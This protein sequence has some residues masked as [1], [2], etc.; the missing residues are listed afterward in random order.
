MYKIHNVLNQ[1]QLDY[2]NN[3]IKNFDYKIHSSHSAQ[4]SIT[5]FNSELLHTDKIKT[6]FFR[7]ILLKILSKSN[8]VL[9][10][11]I[12]C[13]RCYI[14]FYPCQS[15]G[16]FHVDSEGGNLTILYFP[17]E[18]DKND[19]GETIFLEQIG[20]YIYYDGKKIIKDMQNHYYFEKNIKRTSE[21]EIIENK[22][23]YETNSALFF[24]SLHPHRANSHKNKKGRFSI[25]YKCVTF[26]HT[27]LLNK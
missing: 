17:C 2:V 11:N 22:I 21:L 14:N 20:S 18:W 13:I 19:G 10:E 26:D 27:I 8:Y 3:S 25:A 5:F 12:Y 1:I 6:N 23:E 24:N 7:Q 15:E 4:N 16:E 9:N